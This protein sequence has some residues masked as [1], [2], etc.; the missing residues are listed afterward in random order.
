MEA[1]KTRW[2]LENVSGKGFQK[3]GKVEN[4]VRVSVSD[5]SSR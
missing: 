3:T 1:A 4:F 5:I 2:D